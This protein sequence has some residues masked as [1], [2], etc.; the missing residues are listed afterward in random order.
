[1]ATFGRTDLGNLPSGALWPASS[2]TISVSQFNLPKN[3]SSITKLTTYASVF[4]SATATEWKGIIYNDSS[5]TPSSL[6]A[7]TLPAS[8]IAGSW[9]DLVFSNSFVLNSGNYW[10]GVMGDGVGIGTGASVTGINRA[11]QPVTAYPSLTGIFP[12]GTSSVVSTIQK[13]IYATYNE[14]E[15]Y[16]ALK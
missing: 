1:M 16:M 9:I 4:G 11:G 2:S 7:V 8:I 5:N 12:T 13:S 15:W 3:N 6:I 10:L 14:G